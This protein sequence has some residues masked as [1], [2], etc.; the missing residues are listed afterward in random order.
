MEEYDDEDGVARKIFNALKRE[1]RFLLILDDMWDAFNLDEVG[2]PILS[3]ENGYK[4]VLTTRNKGICGQMQAH[5][6]EVRVLSEEES[7]EFF[8]DIVAMRGAIL[9]KDIENLT[10]DVAKECCNLPLAI[11]TIGGSMCGVDNAA[12]WKNALKDLKE[13]NGEFKGIDKVFVPLKFS[14]TRL[15]D[16]VLQY[17]FLYYALYPEDHKISANELIDNWI[18]EDLIEIT[19]VR[20]DNINKG[21]T[22]LD[23][24]I[25][26][27]MLE[28]CNDD[29]YVLGI[30][31]KMHDLIRDMAIIIT[32]TKN[33]QS[34]IYAGQQLQDLSIEFPEDAERISLMHND[35]EAIFPDS[36]F[37]YM[38]S[39]RV[40]NL[41]S[42]KIWSLPKS[43]SNMKNLR[44]LILN[45]C[46]DLEEVPSLERLEE[47]RMLDLSHTKIRELPSG[48]EAMVYLQHLDL[49]CTEELRVFPAGI[50]LRLSHLEEL[51]MDGSKWMLSSK[52]GEG[53]RIEEILNSTRLA[54]LNIQFEELSDFLQHAKSDKWQMMKRFRLSVGSSF[55]ISSP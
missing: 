35:I 9:S 50:I 31:V 49:D 1:K 23:H 6:I 36:Y 34:E 11:K 2:I 10:K 13:A 8:K 20:E 41:S 43:V 51:T 28:R 29:D 33:P 53:A 18:C 32:R 48:M 17:C 42:T 5:A 46:R 45:L 16:T 14:Y 52:T 12:I 27:S 21:H 40:L 7:W 44:A 26:V 19:R 22:I 15:P 30:H 38:C 4:L 55:R 47:L 25:K 39:F 37:N 3:E 54:I 24:L